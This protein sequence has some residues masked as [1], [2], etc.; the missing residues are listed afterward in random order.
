[1]QNALLKALDN[2]NVNSQTLANVRGKKW[3]QQNVQV[4]LRARGLCWYLT[5]RSHWLFQ[6]PNI[7]YLE[8]IFHFL[9]TFVICKILLLCANW[10]N[11]KFKICHQI[12][13]Q[14]WEFSNSHLISTL[15]KY[16]RSSKWKTHDWK[17]KIKKTTSTLPKVRTRLFISNKN[18]T[19]IDMFRIG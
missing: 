17:G 4:I 10:S 3:K 2:Y 18:L 12:T 19:M 8:N 14:F 1:M 6:Y 11:I 15:C 5:K 16:R 9:L 13:A 7:H